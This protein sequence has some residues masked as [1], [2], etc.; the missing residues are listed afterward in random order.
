M[1]LD[2]IIDKYIYL[3]PPTHTCIQEYLEKHLKRKTMRGELVHPDI[4]TYY[5]ASD[6]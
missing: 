6:L 2:K 5:K 4:E 3:P 1:E